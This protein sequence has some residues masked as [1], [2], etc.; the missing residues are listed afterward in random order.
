M[1]GNDYEE[2]AGNML[3]ALAIRLNPTYRQG[4]LKAT[5]MLHLERNAIPINGQSTQQS[6][7][8]SSRS[9]S[10]CGMQSGELASVG[11]KD[12]ET[13]A[14]LLPAMPLILCVPMKTLLPTLT[15]HAPG[16]KSG[17]LLPN[18]NC[19]VT[20]SYKR[21]QSCSLV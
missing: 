2:H 6:G 3:R 10:G 20:P 15:A 8:S 17:F 21:T 13:P 16:E 12:R 4:H 1:M 18:L 9:T 19:S 7:L 14:S 11:Q 5:M